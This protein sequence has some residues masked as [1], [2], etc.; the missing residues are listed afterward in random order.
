V[1]IFIPRLVA[2]AFCLIAFGV[3]IYFQR[4]EQ[5]R[6]RALRNQ[7]KM[8][9]STSTVIDLPAASLTTATVIGHT[10]TQGLHPM[11][12]Q[13]DQSP[14]PLGPIRLGDKKQQGEMTK[15]H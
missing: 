15:P 13:E 12:K 1:N 10:L 7:Q 14:T 3:G 8:N 6:R 2:F 11:W 5:K 9:F 4:Q